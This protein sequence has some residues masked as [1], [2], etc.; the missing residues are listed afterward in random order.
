MARHTRNNNSRVETSAFSFLSGSVIVRLLNTRI[1]TV[2]RVQAVR[3]GAS[4]SKKGRVAM[5]QRTYQ[6]QFTDGLSS[7]GYTGNTSQIT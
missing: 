5:T 2:V 6:V 3:V 1:G 4:L 7:F